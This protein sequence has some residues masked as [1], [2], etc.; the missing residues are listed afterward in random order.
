LSHLADTQ[1]DRQTDIQTNK[2]SLAKIFWA[3][4]YVYYCYAN[5]LLANFWTNST[6]FVDME[7]MINGGRL[8]KIINLPDPQYLC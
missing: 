5:R 6:N 7:T 1:T 4:Y 8:T 3:Y 2:Q